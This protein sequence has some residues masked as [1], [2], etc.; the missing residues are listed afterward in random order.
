MVTNNRNL[1]VSLAWSSL[2]SPHCPTGPVCS[3][4]VV[5]EWSALVVLAVAIDAEGDVMASDV[6]Q[7]K[8]EMRN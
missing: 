5:D 7:L 2:P 1:R 6:V 4:E 8:S 3:V